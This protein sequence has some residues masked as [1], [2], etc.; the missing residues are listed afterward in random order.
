MHATI[1]CSPSGVY[2]TLGQKMTS[3][4]YLSK[5]Q[6]PPELL[7][8][9]E[10][11]W[12]TGPNDVGC[13]EIPPY[14][15]TLKPNAEMP[16]IPQYRISTEGEKALLEIVHDLIQKGVVEE[17]RGNTC[18]SPVLPVLKRTDPSQPPVYRFV[19]DLRE[20]NKIVVPQFPVVPDITA[21]LTMI[22][23]TAT[24]FSVID[25]KNAFFSIPIAEESRDI[26]GFSLG[27]RSFRFKRAPQ[28]YCESPSVYSQAL[29]CHLDA[30]SLPSGAALIQYMDDLLVAADSEEI[31]KNVTVALL[32]HLFDLNHKVSPSKLQYVCREVT[33][34]GH[35][36]SKE[37]RRL[38]PERIQA[39]AQMSVP[40][41]Q[42]EVRAFLGI[43]SY[44]RQWIPSF[45]LLAKPLLALT[46]K[47][48]PQP[49]PWTD[50]CQK[51][52]TD[53][54]IALC[55]APVLGTPD[56]SKPFTLYVHEREGSALSV[57]MQRFGDQ[58]R[59][60]AY[61]SAT[62]DPV[63]KALPSCLKATAAAAIS[64]R[65][66]AGVVLDNTLIVMVPHAVD[67][68][69][70]R[71]KTQHLTSARLSGYELTLLASHIHIKRCN[72][73]NPA[74]LL[75]LP[76]ERD[77]S[78]QHDCF[79]RTEE[80]TKGG[81]DLKDTPLVNPDGTLWV[82]GSCFKLPNG[83]TVSAYA[84]T[85][86]HTIVETA[87]IRHNSAQAA[88]LI[89]LTRACVLSEGK[90]VNVY[91]DS[92]YAFGVAFNFGRLWKER[93]FFTSHGTKIQHGQ[94][95]TEL[96]ES[97]TMPTQIAIVKCSAHK[98]IVD[99]V[100]RGNA[101]AD[102]V[103][104]KTARDNTSRMYVAGPA[105]CVREKGMCEDTVESV[106]SIQ[107]E[108]TEN[109]LRKWKESTGM[110]DEMGC[111]VELSE[112][113]RWLLPDAYVLPVV[114]MAH[115]PAHLSA[116]GICKLLA[117]V[118]QNEGIPKCANNVV[119][120]CIVCLMYNPG[121]G[122]PTPAGHFAP[123][124]YP[125]EVLQIDYIHMERCNNLKYVLVVVWF[126]AHCLE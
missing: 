63:A 39:I 55:S 2:L 6:F 41:T 4:M 26:F 33:Y 74:T 57:L 111:W 60:C 46:L 117:P 21:L 125:F 101:F 98:K 84:I 75:P 105:N 121:K 31:C 85:T 72:T 52:F 100:G 102:E 124:T 11:L 3:P 14:V 25:F 23:S 107:G 116:K 43:T 8:L 24:W 73:L 76:E 118:W 97:L 66:S 69:L 77:V 17:T 59:P 20:V 87:R 35:L 22:P 32:R 93:G 92:Q 54:R 56:Y 67:T 29:K 49:L 89:A 44:C 81:I 99:D 36:L 112:H 120:H 45:S 19:I 34:L 115:G 90:R 82:D 27:G 126:A 78:E 108:A 95:V 53:L 1:Y 61:F 50:E 18:N 62:L 88:E 65:Q 10:T 47:D 58:Q 38:T 94:L 15:V 79:L 123:P 16:R 28:G 86:L 83:D 30:F 42:R 70:N 68:L 106:K 5:D 103:A 48:T 119:K 109:E 104:K 122:T 91:T 110:L 40:S 7:S 80:E 114:T 51:S 12:A 71:T 96:L 64:I 37:G 9:P 13:L 113:Q